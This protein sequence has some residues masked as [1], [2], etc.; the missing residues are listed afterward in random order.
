VKDSFFNWVGV[1]Y[2]W[3]NCT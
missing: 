1:T 2:F 3:R